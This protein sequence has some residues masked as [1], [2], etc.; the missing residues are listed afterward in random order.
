MCYRMSNNSGKD[1]RAERL[2]SHKAAEPV[3]RKEPDSVA[4]GE[5]MSASGFIAMFRRLFASSGKKAA[6]S[7]QN[8]EAGKAITDDRREVEKV[9]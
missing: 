8:D 1:A 3:E 6:N 5:A 7:G 2:S 9:D 4:A